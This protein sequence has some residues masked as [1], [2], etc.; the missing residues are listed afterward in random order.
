LGIGYRAGLVTGY[1]ENLVSWAEDLPIIPFGGIVGWVD[2]GPLG[3]DVFY[4]YR[5]ITLESSIRF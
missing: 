2:V 3:V 4:V 1:D 5:A